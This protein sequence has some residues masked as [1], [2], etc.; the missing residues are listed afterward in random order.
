MTRRRSILVIVALALAFALGTWAAQAWAVNTLV[1]LNAQRAYFG[2]PALLPDP[3][4][5]AEAEWACQVRA[6]N[7]MHG[8]L[9]LRRITDSYGNVRVVKAKVVAG[10]WE[11]TASRPAYQRGPA[12]EFWGPEDVYTCYQN[13]RSARYAGVASVYNPRTRKWYYEANLR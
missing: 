6:N 4:L 8:H 7:N 12:G 1:Y 3:H 11:G 2:L 5:Q 10:K 9:K 13:H